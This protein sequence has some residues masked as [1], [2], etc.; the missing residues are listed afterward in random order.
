[1]SEQEMRRFY[2]GYVYGGGF[3]MERTE[4]VMETTEEV[5]EHTEEKK[6]LNCGA[7]LPEGAL[8]C[9]NCGHRQTGL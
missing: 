8:F 1:M 3:F 7:E 9:S 4:E 6:C 2:G 5:T